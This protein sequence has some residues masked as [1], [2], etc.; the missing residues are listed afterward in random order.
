MN[1]NIK[2]FNKRFKILMYVQ[3]RNNIISLLIYSKKFSININVNM[4]NLFVNN[5]RYIRK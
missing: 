5:M 3:L 1:K 2:I 4:T